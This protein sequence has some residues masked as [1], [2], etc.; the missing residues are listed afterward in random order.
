MNLATY[1][2]NPKNPYNVG[3]ALR[4]TAIFGG[5]G[6]F[7]SGGR[8][9]RA[10]AAKQSRIGKRRLPREERMRAYGKVIWGEDEAAFDRLVEE[11][12]VPV[13]V[14]VDPTF[15][16]LPD[17]VHPE[18]ALYVFG[19]EDGSIPKGTL[20]ACHRFVRI[21]ALGCLNLAAAVNV[22]LYDRA[23]KEG[24]DFIPTGLRYP[25]PEIDLEPAV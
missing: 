24:A 3:A 12:L 2:I 9:N 19:P 22:V 16:S 8:V 7:W 5:D 14:E 20:H 18:R 17:F 15:E 6:C 23:V 1:L 4:A 10:V 11:G 25:T 21:P 13:A